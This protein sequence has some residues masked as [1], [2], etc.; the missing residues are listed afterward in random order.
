MT[1]LGVSLMVATL[2]RA[3]DGA[4]SGLGAA[5][6]VAVGASVLSGALGWWVAQLWSGGGIA[7][8]LAQTLAVGAVVVAVF[9]G[10]MFVLARE[11]TTQTVAVLRRR[12]MAHSP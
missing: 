5:A 9:A 8:A 7:A 6:L 12:G 3:G 11:T 2:R 4:F 1:M 10:T